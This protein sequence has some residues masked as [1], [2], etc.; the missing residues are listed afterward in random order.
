[1]T[2]NKLIITLL[3]TLLTA[4][5]ATSQTPTPLNDAQRTEFIQKLCSTAQQTKH[6]SY[7]FVQSRYVS[8]LA[9][10]AVQEGRMEFEAPSNLKWDYLSPQRLCISLRDGQCLLS[11]DQGNVAI[12]P[13]AQK[14]LRSLTQLIGGLV[15]GTALTDPKQFDTELLDMHN[16]HTMARLTPKQPK[17]KRLY[18]RIEMEVDTNTMRSTAVRLYEPNGDH[19]EIKFNHISTITK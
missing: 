15:D 1:M 4:A 13:Q 7:S 5:R 8:V 9:E 12:P 17:L 16:G 19:T 18:Q 3:L 6:M 14:M 2:M 10:P 11:N